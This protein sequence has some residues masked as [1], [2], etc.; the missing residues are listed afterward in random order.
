MGTR[1][2]RGQAGTLQQHD[3]G[4]GHLLSSIVDLLAASVT[5][6]C[7]NTRD[8]HD[9]QGSVNRLLRHLRFRIRV[10][11]LADA[12]VRGS[13]LRHESV[14]TVLRDVLHHCLFFDVDGHSNRGK[15][16]PSCWWP[17]LGCRRLDCALLCSGL[18]MLHL[19]AGSSGWLEVAC[20]V[21]DFL[22]RYRTECLG[23]VTK[24]DLVLAG[25]SG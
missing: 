25:G 14:R 7:Y 24:V 6:H 23:S 11:H 4:P 21:L 12:G 16:D 17:L 1:P 10:K 8:S 18:G 20:Q 3:R 13:A 19:V 2:A 22:Q 5:T 15:P 9:H